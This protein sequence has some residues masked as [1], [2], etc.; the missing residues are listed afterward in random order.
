LLQR[1]PQLIRS[2][3]GEP[4]KAVYLIKNQAVYRDL[5]VIFLADRLVF[6]PNGKLKEN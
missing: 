6:T 2:S 3:L 1:K 4:Y 5:H